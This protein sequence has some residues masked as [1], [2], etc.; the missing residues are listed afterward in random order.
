M[1]RALRSAVYFVLERAARGLWTLAC[2]VY[3][4]PTWV[5][6]AS[7]RHTQIA[8]TPRLLNI[9]RRTKNPAKRRVKALMYMRASIVPGSLE[10]RNWR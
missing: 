10:T 7:K 6:E 8:Q 4:Y 9:W 1:K 5:I 2:K 3:D